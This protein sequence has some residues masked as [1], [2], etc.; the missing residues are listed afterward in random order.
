MLIVG[1][2]IAYELKYEYSSDSKYYDNFEPPRP[3][4]LK[5]YEE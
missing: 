3:I 2:K 1:S 4:D 5:Y